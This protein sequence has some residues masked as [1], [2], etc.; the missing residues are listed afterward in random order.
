M[1][2]LSE[3]NNPEVAKDYIMNILELE[4]REH[5]YKILGIRPPYNDGGKIP[6][7]RTK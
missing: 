1:P 7:P 6:S 5:K 4:S 3:I 2:D